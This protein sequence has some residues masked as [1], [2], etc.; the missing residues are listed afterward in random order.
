M[1]NVHYG[2][3]GSPYSRRPHERGEAGKVFSPKLVDILR[4]KTQR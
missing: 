3:K 1:R 2:S 4:E